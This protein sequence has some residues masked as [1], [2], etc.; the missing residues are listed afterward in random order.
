M[1]KPEAR[2]DRVAATEL[3]AE[4][5]DLAAVDRVVVQ[6]TDIHLPFFQIVR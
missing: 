1:G 6:D 5:V 2:T 4:T 3:E